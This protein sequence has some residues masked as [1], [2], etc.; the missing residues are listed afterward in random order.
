MQLPTNFGIDV[1]LFR[2][3]FMAS[4]DIY[5]KEITDMY[6]PGEPLPGVFGAS[7][8]RVNSAD[9]QVNG[10][11]ISLSYQNTFTLKDKP[12]KFKIAASV[13]NSK[14]EITKYSNPNGLLS[15][16]YEGQELGEIWGYHVDGQFQ[17]DEEATS[18]Q[19]SFVDPSSNLSEVYNF[20]LNVAQ[21][22]D[23]KGLKAGDLKFLDLDGDGRIDGGDNTLE[24]HGDLRVIGNAAPKF[25]FGFLIDTEW[26][27]FDFMAQGTGV[28]SQDWYPTG[29]L[30][31]GTYERPYVAYIRKD[32]V[33]NAW[34]E[35]NP[36]GNFPQ[37]N[38]SYTALA[39]NRQLG[40]VNNHFLTN[41]GYLRIK[42]LTLGYTLPQ[43]ITQ[44]ISIERLRF[45]LSGENLFTFRFGG[46]TKYLDPEQAGSGVNLSDPKTAT[47]RS[48]VEDYPINKIISLGINISL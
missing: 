47:N 13:S 46:L 4:L 9:L 32:L 2:N 39:S 8:P 14:G 17:S 15:S 30:Y 1:G 6:L 48:R 27:G 34:S 24:D 20:A 37:I 11:D 31:W 29:R 40:A 44:K 7:E 23:F 33:S 3:K 12:L 5:K 19:N 36:N 25:P 26:N 42:N 18:Y 10:F 38:R 28:V 45:Y 41:L 21:N 35:D 22:N 43:N 16:F